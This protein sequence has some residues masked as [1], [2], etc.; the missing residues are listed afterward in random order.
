MPAPTTTTSA[1]SRLRPRRSSSC[2]AATSGRV[3]PAPTAAAPPSSPR[4]VTPPRLARGW[5]W[6][7][8]VTG[9]LFY[10]TRSAAVEVLA[11]RAQ[12]EGPRECP[13]EIIF[14]S[15]TSWV[16]LVVPI[17]RAR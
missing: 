16:G 1:L 14:R 4:R 12:G 13:I 6:P 11:C 10:Q 15:S 5:M 17:N 3:A 9:G 8:A 7:A 2:A